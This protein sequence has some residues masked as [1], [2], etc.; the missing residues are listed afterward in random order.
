[1]I[2]SMHHITD[3]PTSQSGLT[4]HLLGK[5]K[6][7]MNSL[8]TAKVKQRWRGDKHHR[9]CWEVVDVKTCHCPMRL[10]LPFS[11]LYHPVAISGGRHIQLPH[12]FLLVARYLEARYLHYLAQVN[13]A[14]HTSREDK[15]STSFDL[16]M[17]GWQI[18]NCGIPYDTRVLIVFTSVIALLT[19]FYF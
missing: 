16:R 11:T 18:K 19:C 6:R 17:A 4:V 2:N 8:G 10:P 7:Q 1:M 3:D 12:Y 13:S 15:S 9:H 5:I 14:F